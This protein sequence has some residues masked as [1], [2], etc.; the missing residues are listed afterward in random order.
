MIVWR[1]NRSDA[2]PATY[3]NLVNLFLYVC[4]Y[5]SWIFIYTH[6]HVSCVWY[7]VVCRYTLYHS[8]AL[9]WFVRRHTRGWRLPQV[10]PSLPLRNKGRLRP[11][12]EVRIVPLFLL[13]QLAFELGSRALGVTWSVCLLNFH[14][15]LR[16]TRPQTKQTNNQLKLVTVFLL[17]LFHSVLFGTRVLAVSVLIRQQCRCVSWCRTVLICV[18]TCFYSCDILV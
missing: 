10:T 1:D 3:P 8:H 12:Y 14:A 17:S 16:L 11:R 18:T 7:T 4:F 15:L 13:G 2:N 6:T 9:C 5:T